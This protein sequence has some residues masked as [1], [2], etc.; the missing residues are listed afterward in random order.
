MFDNELAAMTV[1]PRCACSKSKYARQHSK[2]DWF[3]SNVRSLLSL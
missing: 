2:S 3:K 1:A